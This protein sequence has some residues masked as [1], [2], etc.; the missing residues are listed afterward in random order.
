MG[1]FVG[2][3]ER[4]G[5]SLVVH[6]GGAARARTYATDGGEAWGPAQRRTR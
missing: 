5:E 4:A 1:Q 3:D 2:D 6:N